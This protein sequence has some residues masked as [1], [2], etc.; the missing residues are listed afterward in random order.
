MDVLAYLKENYET[1][2]LLHAWRF[3]GIVDVYKSKPTI[4][5]LPENKYYRFSNDEEFADIAINFL[6]FYPPRPAFKKL[7]S[8]RMAYQEFKHHQ[9]MDNKKTKRQIMKPQSQY[10]GQK[11]KDDS[12]MPY[13]I[14]QGEKMANIPPDYLVWL[15]EN[16]KCSPAVAFYVSENLDNLKKEIANNKK[17]IR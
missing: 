5:V 12:K 3:N 10:K 9:R 16:N 13:G 2:E 8:G 6:E 14:H 17:G 4:F 1:I 7:P 11:L 15:F